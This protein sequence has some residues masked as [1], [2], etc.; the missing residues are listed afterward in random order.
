M[1]KDLAGIPY[2]RQA[3]AEGNRLCGAAALAMAYGS[4]GKTVPQ[5]EIWPKISKRNN[6]G[7][8]A[9]ATYLMAQDAI[10][11]GFFALAIQTPQPLQALRVCRDK[12][13]R[14]ILS[15][16]LRSDLGA[17][18]YTVLVGLDADDVVLHDPY[19][20][21]SRRVAN[22]ALLE[23]WRPGYPN[24]EITGNVLIGVADKSEPLP[25]CSEC[26]TVMPASVTCAAC[27]RA[28]AL[29]PAALL[30]CVGPSCSARLWTHLCCP[31]CDY[32]WSFAAQPGQGQEQ[33]TGSA[34]DP[35]DLA[36]L[37]VELDKFR[38]HVQSS[39][40]GS[41]PQVREQLDFMMASK[42]KLALSQKEQIAYRRAHEAKL[43]QMKTRY[44]KEEER[45]RKQR[46]EVT[47]PGAPLDGNA[48][49]QALLKS[50]GLLPP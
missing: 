22:T 34:E 42:E 21:P 1:S 27:H 25:P 28:I 50:L 8:L 30:G 23:L 39:K 13:I 43:A 24:A 20:G 48:L 47:R 4:F 38:D 17:G 44:G 7:S 35:L 5:A 14:A 9:S 16:R 10:S 41:N 6:L 46:E 45:V 49:G 15:H 26:G 18:H 2:E 12:G 36:R 3:D 32:T 29:Q 33:P 37:F 11:R 40:A 31:F 19:Y